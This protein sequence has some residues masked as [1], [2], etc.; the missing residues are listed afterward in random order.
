LDA[1]FSVAL[2]AILSFCMSSGSIGIDYLTAKLITAAV[3][4]RDSGEV[5]GS[6][7]ILEALLAASP[8]HRQATLELFVIQVIVRN[9]TDAS[10]KL[11]AKLSAELRQDPHIALLLSRYYQMIGDYTRA[12]RIISRIPIAQ[13]ESVPSFLSLW[14]LVNFENSYERIRHIDITALLS[15]AEASD[16]SH[17]IN[18][19]KLGQ[20]LKS[21][22][23]TDAD[24][25]SL[26]KLLI[27]LAFHRKGSQAIQLEKLAFIVLCSTDGSSTDFRA[28]AFS[29]LVATRNFDFAQRMVDNIVSR[30]EIV[31]HPTFIKWLLTYLTSQENELARHYLIHAFGSVFGHNT[32]QTPRKE[33]AYSKAPLHELECRARYLKSISGDDDSFREAGTLPPSRFVPQPSQGLH[34]FVG[35]FGQ[36]RFGG[37]TLPALRHY[38]VSDFRGVVDAGALLSCGVAT[39]RSSGKRAI[40][41]LDPAVFILDRLPPGLAVKVADHHVNSVSDVAAL[42]P[43]IARFIIED[44]LNLA[45]V[46][47]T[48]INTLFLD[49]E[50][51]SS[52]SWLDIADDQTFD[53]GLGRLMLKEWGDYNSLLNQG[54]MW[55]RINALKK[56]ITNAETKA[57][58]PVTHCVI[59]R[60]DLY[61]HS[62]SL[63]KHM[64][65]LIETKVENWA[66]VD[67]DPHANFIDGLGDRFIAG[68]RVAIE[69]VL[70]G[71]E[72]C[73]SILSPES[74]IDLSYK[75]CFGPHELLD[76]LLFEHGTAVT[77]L[78]PREISFE[79]HRGRL[80]DVDLRREIA[81]DTID[82]PSPVIRNYLASL[83]N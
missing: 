16:E 77:Q 12:L 65:D 68:D 79:I 47:E 2:K 38:L 11:E 56:L 51:G 66:I 81:S 28:V 4:L 61:F 43:S 30:D 60:S 49:Q 73:T 1:E 37:K 31:W 3:A 21:F 58:K 75:R 62:G 39:W 72:L 24:P 45:T 76:T 9:D 40:S 71:Y 46:D 74:G 13:V 33:W 52:N 27:H 59:M 22:I 64:E 41:L 15:L 26:Q 34:V 32:G 57:K 8:S 5:D 70:T 53:M 23:G 29:F 17:E 50:G 69:R 36:L 35:L 19:S 83:F 54:R 42:I 67:H 14:R 10:G 18:R 20:V 63:W 25:D 44:S 80:D 7:A 78:T 48:Q 6:V 82:S 55:H